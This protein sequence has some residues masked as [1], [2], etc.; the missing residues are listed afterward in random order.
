[1]QRE[2][3]PVESR[4]GVISG[5]VLLVLISSFVGALIAV[6]LSWAFLFPH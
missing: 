5:R 6:G 1:M 2:L 4:G 3:N